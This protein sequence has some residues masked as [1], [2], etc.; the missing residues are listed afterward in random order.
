M[1]TREIQ[2]L[3]TKIMELLAVKKMHFP[4]YLLAYKIFHLKSKIKYCKAE[5]GP[6]IYRNCFSTS[7]HLLDS[8]KL[9]SPYCKINFENVYAK[10]HTSINH[11]LFWEIFDTT[12][13][14]SLLKTLFNLMMLTFFKIL[15]WTSSDCSNWSTTAHSIY[16]RELWELFSQQIFAQE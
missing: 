10:T 15:L 13:C 9:A 8:C 1:Q 12:S 4:K 7:L 11:R 6:I 14:R 3:S 2:C 5:T 16:K